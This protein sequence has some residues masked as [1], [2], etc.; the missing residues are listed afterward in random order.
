MISRCA[1]STI[2]RCYT[3]VDPAILR[4]ALPLVAFCLSCRG[5]FLFHRAEGIIHVGHR[6]TPSP[7]IDFQLS[8]GNSEA[9]EQGSASHFR[10]GAPLNHV[11]ILCLLTCFGGFMH[12]EVWLQIGLAGIVL[13]LIDDCCTADMREREPCLAA[14]SRRATRS[15]TF[16]TVERV[17]YNHPLHELNRR[18]S[19]SIPVN[20][21]RLSSLWCAMVGVQISRC[22]QWCG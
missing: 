6:A 4:G 2:A 10:T 19:V 17:I 20:T 13:P 9:G 15:R 3:S 11:R 22:I 21:C 1:C 5:I 8:C 12:P 14:L 18:G 7:S 16:V